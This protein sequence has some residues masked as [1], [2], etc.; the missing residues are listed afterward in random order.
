MAKGMR[1]DVF[2]LTEAFG[3]CVNAQS[4]GAKQARSHKLC[5]FAENACEKYR[6]YGFGYCSV[7]Y[8]ARDDGGTQYKY[9]VCDHRLDG[10]PL[11]EVLREHFGP[12]S[13]PEL[14]PEIKLHDL[15]TSIDYVAVTRNASGEIEEVIAIETQAIDLRG[16][17]VGPAWEAWVDG[18]A[19]DWR[20]YFTKEAL[21]KGRKDNVAYGVNM[22]NITKRLGLQ[23]AI[24]GTYLKS[25]G[26]PLYVVM[27]DRPFNYLLKRIPFVRSDVNEVADINFVTFDY[28]DEVLTDGRLGFGYR[29][30]VR[31]S[32]E[33]F[34]AALSG[35]KKDSSSQRQ[36]FFD[37]INKKAARMKPS[38][39]QR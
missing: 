33:S 10:E 19:E 28:E 6:Q 11:R 36:T 18:A 12:G 32:L 3:Y 2:P 20:Q 16:G 14:I 29:Q 13:A 25:M 39:A 34:S 35:G 5:P 21:K 4:D 37:A 27:Q 24:K 9:A 8:A 26:V 22:A 23:V 31:V 17:G 38:L 1:G 7:V 15:R 30:T